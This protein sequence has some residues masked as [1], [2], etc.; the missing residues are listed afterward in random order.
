MRKPSYQKL[1]DV[2]KKDILGGIYREGDFLPSEN[3]LSRSYQMTRM[4][5]RQ[6]LDGLVQDGYI[7]KQKGR[8]SIVSPKRKSLGLLSIRGFSDALSG[9]PF[10]VNTQIL[11]PP[12]RISWPA[13]F[14]YPLSQKEEKSDCICLKRLRS[15][16]QEPVM[17]EHTYIPDFGLPRFGEEPFVH[18]SLFET[19]N[20][21]Y[22]IEI[23]NVEQDLRA[24][25]SDSETARLLSVSVRDPLL[26]IF[27]KY[28]TNRSGFYIYSALYCNTK[29]YAIGNVFK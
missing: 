20:N 11:T 22:H 24:I 16:G 1:Q 6:A 27:R 23:V 14:F 8:G 12:S 26:H 25:L 10:P 5:V 9:F 28:H 13:G 21:R 7:E 2:L 3:E 4:T 15:A 29:K 17:L 19:L 18:D